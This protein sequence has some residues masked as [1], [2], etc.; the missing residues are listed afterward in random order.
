MTRAI[1]RAQ[2]FNGELFPARNVVAASAP[3]KSYTPPP[4]ILQQKNCPY[5]HTP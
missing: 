2:A 3:G 4:L 1:S 5:E